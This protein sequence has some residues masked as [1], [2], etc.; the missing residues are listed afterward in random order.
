MALAGACW[1]LQSACKALAKCLHG[2]CTRACKAPA[3]CLRRRSR[4][5]VRA[6]HAAAHVQSGPLEAESEDD[7]ESP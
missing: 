2:A 6:R 4:L 5:L 7:D 3:K 1:C